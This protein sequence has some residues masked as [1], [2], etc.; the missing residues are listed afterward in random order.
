VKQATVSG[1]TYITSTN[2]T[3]LVY[4]NTGLVNGTLYYFVVSATNSFGESTN[5]AQVSARPVS[6]ASPQITFGNNGGQIYVGWPADHTGW[7]LQMQTNSVDEGLGTNW[8][9]VSGSD[10]TNQI[11]IPINTVNGSA[12]FRLVAP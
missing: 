7:W 6:T 5:S 8:A 4:T 2:V 10:A 9:N 11:S 3:G 1:G 12:F